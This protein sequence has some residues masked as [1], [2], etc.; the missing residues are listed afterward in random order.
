VGTLRS[1]STTRSPFAQQLLAPQLELDH[2][3]HTKD[4]DFSPAGIRHRW[5]V[6]PAHARAVLAREPWV[7]QFDPLAGVILHKPEELKPLAA[8]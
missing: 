7:G 3:G 2:E 4:V 5:D 6:S 8:E 1:R